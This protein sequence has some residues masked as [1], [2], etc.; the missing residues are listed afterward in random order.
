MPKLLQLGAAAGIAFYALRTVPDVLVTPVDAQLTARFFIIFYA[1]FFIVNRIAFMAGSMME[2]AVD[3]YSTISY[4][5][6]N[7]GD[8]KLIENFSKKRRRVF[9]K[10]FVGC[11]VTVALGILSSKLATLI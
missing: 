4:L 6:L 8:R 3:S 11:L 10:F 7:N 1:G 5:K 2:D 9:G